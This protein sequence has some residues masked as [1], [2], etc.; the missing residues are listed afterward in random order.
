[1]SN[2][3]ET[4]QAAEL[5]TSWKLS[6]AALLSAAVV[7]APD[8]ALAQQIVP[9][10]TNTPFGTVFCTVVGWF[11]SNTGK[12]L[13]TLAVIII[14]IG[15]LLGKV[16]WGMAL[17]VGTGVAIVFGAIGIVDAIGAGAETA[18]CVTTS[19]F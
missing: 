8:F 10:G 17:I 15:A 3:T 19:D 12:G 2:E 5:S 13:A 6:F 9:A 14:G 7:L 4:K 18:D 11:L 16:S 1:M